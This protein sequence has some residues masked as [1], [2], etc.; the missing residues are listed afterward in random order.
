MPTDT[1]YSTAA[2]SS[3][4][5][6]SMGGQDTEGEAY[7]PLSKLKKYFTAHQAAKSQEISE[8]IEARQYYHGSQ[9]TSEQAKKL[10]ARNQPIM[11]YNQINIKI[12]SNVG[13]IEERRQAP[14]A[15]ARTRQH[16]EGADLVTACIRTVLDQ[17]QWR[18]MTPKIGRMAA[19][20]GIGGVELELE[21]SKF[22]DHDITMTSVLAD[23]FF[24]DPSSRQEDFSDADY[25]GMSV[26]LRQA[27]A[28]AMFPGVDFSE[29]EGASS[30]LAPRSDMES[31]WVGVEEDGDKWVRIVECWY[32]H[33]GG[34][35]YATFTG[36]QILEEGK[37]PFHDEKGKPFCKYV[38]YSGD[39]DQA[40][41]RYGLVR[42][43][44]SPQDGLNTKQ[45]KAQH[46][47][48][49]NKL[50]ITLGAVQDIEK[51]RQEYARADGIIQ[52][53]LPV[54]D[55]IKEVD[56]T[57]DFAG[58]MKLREVDDSY[59]Q[60]YG[61]NV[62]LT[63][64]A[65]QA[66]SGRAIALNQQS[67]L[68]ALGPYLSANKAWKIQVY[69]AVWFAIKEHWTAE[70]QINATDDEE[71]KQFVDINKL[72]VDPMTGQPTLVNAIGQLD[73][74][75]V[76]D[77]GPDTVTM[78]Q[79]MYET[80]SQVVPALAPML[81]PAE[82]RAMVKMLIDTSPLSASEKKTFR[83]ATKQAQQPDPMQQAMQ[84]LQMA[85][86][87]AKVHLDEAG[88]GLKEAQT[89]KTMIEARLAPAQMAAD[90]TMNGQ[91]APM[92]P[93]P[94]ELP[95]ELQNAQAMADIEETR[96]SSQHK[97]AQAFKTEQEARLAPQQMLFDLANAN[98]D[99]DMAQR[100]A[101]EDRKIA[102]KKAAQKPQAQR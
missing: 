100:K 65:P 86:G 3:G 47:V 64:T 40:G 76:L 35:C 41:D 42:N 39:V 50:F 79:D 1:G 26:K 71:M 15:Y 75:I 48:A 33:K 6:S 14:K 95:P 55:G 17:N 90:A 49:S 9:W 66:K 12:N 37:S 62:D 45:S 24:Y 8:Q 46:V 59:I 28:E 36:S 38:M 97:Q 20:D 61:P 93:Q 67:G 32:R 29:L 94:Y 74:D 27:K 78:M 72:D 98:A 30:D 70:R 18:S 54:G 68:R 60:N 99:R 63:G 80:L 4:A 19:I 10:K 85:G 92:A 91:G 23:R 44:K 101:D 52:S 22:G 2:P 102:A 11:T 96:A 34:W 73:V 53:H 5:S 58:L 13:V 51:T 69:R 31:R 82:A 43:M 88:A 16:E 25:M 21:P 81:A 84:Q 57:F 7:L 56:R 89:A 87:Q 77:E 83:D